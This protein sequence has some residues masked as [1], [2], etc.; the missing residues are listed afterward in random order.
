MTTSSVADLLIVAKQYQRLC[1][2][3]AYLVDNTDQDA[4]IDFVFT[5]DWV[6][7]QKEIKAVIKHFDGGNECALQA[8]QQTTNTMNA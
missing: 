5:K 3:M 7:S 2:I 6:D 4:I 1:Q 8:A